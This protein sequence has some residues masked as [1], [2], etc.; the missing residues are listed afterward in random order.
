MQASNPNRYAAHGLKALLG[1]LTAVLEVTGV[2]S[3]EGRRCFVGDVRKRPRI[4]GRAAGGK[5]VEPQVG[6]LMCVAGVGHAHLEDSGVPYHPRS[7]IVEQLARGGARVG[8]A[9]HGLLV[10]EEGAEG[11]AAL[12]QADALAAGVALL[13]LERRRAVEQRPDAA[14]EDRPRRPGPR[15][16][17]G[18]ARADGDAAVDPLLGGVGQVGGGEVVVVDGAVPAALARRGDSPTYTTCASGRTRLA[19]AGRSP[20]RGRSGRRRWCGRGSAWAP[21]AWRWRAAAGRPR[22]R[23]QPSARA[24]PPGGHCRRG[25]EH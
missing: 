15:G 2:A 12:G 19:A 11:A 14:L 1:A 4:C 17:P 24:S 23:P 9:G 10:L 20:G 13:Q 21:S 3:H 8:I 6:Q 5:W 22:A 7:N 18:L 25:D 16:V